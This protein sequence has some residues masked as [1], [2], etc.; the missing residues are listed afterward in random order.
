MQST[1]ML[2]GIACAGNMTDICF[3]VQGSVSA[4]QAVM[5]GALVTGSAVAS[6]TLWYYSRRYV[7]ELSLVRRLGDTQARLCFSVLDF[8][9]NRE[10][11]RWVSMWMKLSRIITT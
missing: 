11:N 1:A 10:V 8:W 5:A 7:G 3:F 9:G 2:I 6:V 4:V